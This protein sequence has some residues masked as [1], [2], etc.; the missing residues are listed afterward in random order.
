M[1]TEEGALRNG[2]P[3]PFF[4]AYPW[5]FAQWMNEESCLG[6]NKQNIPQTKSAMVLSIMLVHW[7]AVCCA[8]CTERFGAVHQKR[9][10]KVNLLSHAPCAL[11]ESLSRPTPLSV[12]HLT[13][14]ISVT[15]ALHVTQGKEQVGEPDVLL[16]WPV[17]WWILHGLPWLPSSSTLEELSVSVDQG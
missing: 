2:R 4:E 7:K 5:G 8:N 12:I 6:W 1:P 17:G 16:Y 10:P 15:W 14:H 9:Q 3:S 11:R 13:G